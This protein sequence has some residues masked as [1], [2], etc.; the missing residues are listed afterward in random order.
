M[1]PVEESLRRGRSLAHRRRG[2]RRDESPERD[3]EEEIGDAE[4]VFGGFLGMEGEEVVFVHC[5]CSLSF[6]LVEDRTRARGAQAAFGVANPAL[7]AW[8]PSAW[9]RK[10]RKKKRAR[11][12]RGAAAIMMR[13]PFQALERGE[14]FVG[15]S[16]SA[17]H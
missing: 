3:E 6:L 10:P 5:V 2:R 11:S 12:A 16:L 1:E 8:G 9:R 14:R 17:W 15:P 7:A 4:Q 13:P